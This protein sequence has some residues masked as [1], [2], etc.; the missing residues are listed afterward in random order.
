M[1]PSV[2]ILISLRASVVYSNQEGVGL[3]QKTCLFVKKMSQQMAHFSLHD[4]GPL[5][6]LLRRSIL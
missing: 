2:V 4:L 1:M 5:E 3:R 6:D